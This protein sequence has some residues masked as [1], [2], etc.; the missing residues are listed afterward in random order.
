MT[1]INTSNYTYLYSKLPRGKNKYI[2]QPGDGAG[3]LYN[4]V[5]PV[6]TSYM[7]YSEAVK[8]IKKKWSG[9]FEVYL[10][11]AVYDD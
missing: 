10:L 11:D 2:F 1:I 4:D 8:Y 3:K 5:N 9:Y 6:T 7:T